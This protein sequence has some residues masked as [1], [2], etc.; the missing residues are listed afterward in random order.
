MEGRGRTEVV[1]LKGG[2]GGEE[3]QRQ[4]GVAAWEYPRNGG[5]HE[6]KN[7]TGVTWR[8]NRVL[9]KKRKAQQ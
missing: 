7:G 4:F 3:V 9:G 8:L 5:R 1:R 6:D 2:V